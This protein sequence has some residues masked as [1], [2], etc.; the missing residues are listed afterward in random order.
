MMICMLSVNQGTDFD[1]PLEELPKHHTVVHQP[2]YPSQST[3]ITYE[4]VERNF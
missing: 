1:Q 3:V 2:V 4:M